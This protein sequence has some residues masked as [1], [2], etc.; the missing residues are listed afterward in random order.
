MRG[1]KQTDPGQNPEWPTALRIR[2]DGNAIKVTTDINAQASMMAA[3][4]VSKYFGDG[5]KGEYTVSFRVSDRYED[6]TFKGIFVEVWVDGVAVEW[7]SGAGVSADGFVPPEVLEAEW[8]G[9]EYLIFTPGYILIREHYADI[10]IDDAVK[11]IYIGE[12]LP[13]VQA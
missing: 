5:S 2:I 7:T 11:E 3:L 10:E 9:E 13:A 6:G 12:E 8:S 4:D 1:P